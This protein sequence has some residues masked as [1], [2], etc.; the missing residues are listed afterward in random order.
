[1]KPNWNALIIIGALLF[2]QIVIMG[3]PIP[4][5]AIGFTT[6][7]APAVRHLPPDPNN[8]PPTPPDGSEIM[9][10]ESQYSH[11]YV[12]INDTLTEVSTADAIYSGLATNDLF[13]PFAIV[14]LDDVQRVNSLH[15]TTGDEINFIFSDED[16]FVFNEYYPFAYIPDFTVDTGVATNLPG[17]LGNT[18]VL[19][20]TGS[21]L[22]LTVVPFI[23]HSPDP[24]Y[25][26]FNP[27]VPEPATIL[28]FGT[29]LAGL[30]SVGRSKRRKQQ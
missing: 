5:L 17:G 23:G 29:G 20:D 22:A 19:V 9:W 1:M 10:I 21:F 2:I 7:A 26:P 12:Q 18:F 30:A 4:A 13:H 15:L 24:G 8:P 11:Y 6:T 14:S 16:T 3:K 27:A 28:L 25:H